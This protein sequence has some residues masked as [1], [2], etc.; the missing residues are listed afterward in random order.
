MSTSFRQG[1]KR[2]WDAAQR[3]T[4][5]KPVVLVVT[6]E[7]DLAC[8][9]VDQIKHCFHISV[10]SD[11]VGVLTLARYDYPDVILV[12]AATILTG[13]NDRL[14]EIKSYVEIAGFPPVILIAGDDELTKVLAKDWR[15][16]D[17]LAKPTSPAE[18]L[19]R[20]ET[21]YGACRRQKDLDKTRAH[22]S[23]IMDNAPA[24]IVLLKPI[25][26]DKDDFMI[27][28]VNLNINRV[29]GLDRQYL[30]VGH[31]LAECLRP[32]V[33]DGMYRTSEIDARIAERMAW[34][35]SRPDETIWSIF[36]TINDRYVRT[37]R[38]PHSDYGFVVVTVDTTDQVNAERALAVKSGQF[39]L[40]LEN[41]PC[42][43]RS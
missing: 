21:Q 40:M 43:R 13:S 8:F 12:D 28:A 25:S 3:V 23:L 38:S 30:F 31:S 41:M 1:P 22:L 4:E 36:P 6:P 14:E 2:P 42:R 27:E 34:Y 37:T 39:D 7:K 9:I 19:F 10:V 11:G 18:L 24:G 15:P 5:P 32:A 33:S 16:D 29:A 35:A 17:F 26:G 20:I